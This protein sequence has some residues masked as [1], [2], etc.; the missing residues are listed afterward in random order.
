[1]KLENCRACKRLVTH[2]KAVRRKHPDWHNRPVPEIGPSESRLLILGLAPGMRGANRTGKP[3]FGDKSS[4]WLQSRLKES[5]CMDPLTNTLTVRISNAV[6]CLP[7]GNKPTGE[8]IRQ[9]SN[10]WLA[11]ELETASVVLALGRVAHDAV[12]RTLGKPLN[13]FVF[14][15]GAVHELDSLHLVDTY[16]PSPLNTQTGRLSPQQFNNALTTAIN[17]VS[18]VDVLGGTE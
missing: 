5:G 17:T 16:H 18:A 11:K 14:S 10:R 12:L 6:K 13:A 15:Q 9:C 4:E 3:F 1:M 7:P 8:E 2:L